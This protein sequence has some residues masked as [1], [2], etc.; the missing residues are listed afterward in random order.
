MNSCLFG[1][2]FSTSNT[3]KAKC[4]DE[5][6]LLNSLFACQSF[7]CSCLPPGV[8]PDTGEARRLSI[9]TLDSVPPVWLICFVLSGDYKCEAVNK[10]GEAA[11]TAHL[12]VIRKRTH[13]QFSQKLN[14]SIENVFFLIRFKS[15]S[16]RVKLS[17]QKCQHRKRRSQALNSSGSWCFIFDVCTK[18]TLLLSARLSKGA[19]CTRS[20]Y[21]THNPIDNINV[22]YEQELVLVWNP[23]N[24]A[25][26]AICFGKPTAWMPWLSVDQPKR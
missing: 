14:C 11:L 13:S 15:S 3:T 6:A 7:H 1:R 23:P 22:L 2:N 20:L 9:R 5:S 18:L 17:N 4:S 12:T 8:R 16:S 21:Q 24:V 26:E 25:V 10:F 19:N